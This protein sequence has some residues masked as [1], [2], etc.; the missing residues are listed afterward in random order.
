MQEKADPEFEGASDMTKNMCPDSLFLEE[1]N[2]N[3][4]T[5][6]L[7]LG[8]VTFEKKYKD[9]ICFIWKLKLNY[10]CFNPCHSL[11]KIKQQK[12]WVWECVFIWA[13]SCIKYKN[14]RITYDDFSKKQIFTKINNISSFIAML[15]SPTWVL[16]V[17]K[18]KH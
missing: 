14:P 10:D 7:T 1:Y 8:F 9:T 17:V 3:V 5:I 6:H 12:Q 18:L 2:L 13:M 16:V 4:M 15:S 11:D